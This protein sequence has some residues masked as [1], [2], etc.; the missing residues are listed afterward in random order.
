[1]EKTGTEMAVL[2]FTEKELMRPEAVFTGSDD[3]ETLCFLL[4][5]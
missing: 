5:W 3:E 2:G 1:M 4:E